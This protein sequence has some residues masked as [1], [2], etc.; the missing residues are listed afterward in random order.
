VVHLLFITAFVA[1]ESELL[2]RGL[3]ITLPLVSG[4]QTG[5]GKLG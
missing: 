4:I 1:I 2:H 3:Q 5:T